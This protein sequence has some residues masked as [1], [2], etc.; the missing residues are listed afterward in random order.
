MTTTKPQQEYNEVEQPDQIIHISLN[1]E[2]EQE[3]DETDSCVK[4]DYRKI[5]ERFSANKQSREIEAYLHNG[6]SR[7]TFVRLGM[8]AYTF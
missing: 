8:C 2:T 7:L 1:S 3:A 4:L 6:G 5:D